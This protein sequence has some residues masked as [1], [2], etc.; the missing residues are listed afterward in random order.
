MRASLKS[1]VEK[2]IDAKRVVILDS[3]NYIKG[4]RY[5]LFCLARNAKTTICLVFCDTD[6]DV[7]AKF[8]E[9]G[10]YE[11]AFPKELFADY[12]GRLERPNPAQ[13][14]DKP[15]FHLRFDEETPLNDIAKACFVGKKPR[16][17]VSTKPV[18]NRIHRSIGKCLTLYSF[19]MNFLTRTLSLSSIRR[20]RK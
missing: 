17:P 4:F 15:L 19:R 13:R 10:N 7:A 9:E 18:S 2:Y 5:E 3:M 12:A 8:A 1:N 6:V 20:V 16:E 11:N 14:W